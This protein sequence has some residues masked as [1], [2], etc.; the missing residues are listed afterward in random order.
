MSPAKASIGCTLF[1]YT[2]SVDFKISANGPTS[3]TFQR[4]LSN[5]KSAPPETYSWAAAGTKDFSDSYRVG[6]VGSHWF[7]VHVTSP[8]DISGEDS[9]MMNCT[10]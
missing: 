10:P 6:E 4:L 7:R 5:G 8:N 3:V 9:A 1:P 2:F